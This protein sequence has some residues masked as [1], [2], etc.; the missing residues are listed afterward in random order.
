V[1]GRLQDFIDGR[2]R[3]V[4]NTCILAEEIDRAQ[5]EQDDL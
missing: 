2:K 1:N 5:E 4:C 3:W